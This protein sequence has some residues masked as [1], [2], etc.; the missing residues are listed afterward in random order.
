MKTDAIL[1][2]AGGALA[3][4]DGLA[5]SLADLARRSALPLSGASCH[6]AQ[7]SGELYAYFELRHPL[8]LDAAHALRLAGIARGSAPFAGRSLEA[9]RLAR[10]LDVS[11]ASHGER[12]PFHYVVETDAAEGWFDELIRWYNGEHMPGLAAVPGCV[13]AQ[14]WVNL[15][16]SPRSFA[17]Y[18]LVTRE[19]LGSPPW[20]A[21]R[22]SAWSSRVRPNFRNTKRTMFRSL[23]RSAL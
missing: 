23:T 3:G 2:K 20:L 22:G 12:A 8:E 11:G 17:C 15:D 1:L 4:E 10:G 18:D 13:R 7:E 21:V 14:R 9:S 5:A 19:T 16:A 6:V